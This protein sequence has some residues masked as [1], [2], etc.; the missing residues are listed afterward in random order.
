MTLFGNSY[1]AALEQFIS[2]APLYRLAVL[3][4][5]SN[6][7]ED[8][9]LN[10]GKALS[11]SIKL[12][13]RQNE[14]AFQFFVQ[15]ALFRII[16]EHTFIDPVLGNVV[17]I[18]NLGILFERA[19]DIDVTEVLQRISRNTLTILLWPGEVDK[20]SLSFLKSSSEHKIKQSEINYIIL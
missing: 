10:I 14:I 20:Y 17:V 13:D 7:R 19:L 1:D 16:K 18:E 4:V 9:A 5:E 12:M 15:E 2:S 11:N 8:N 3:K 6:A